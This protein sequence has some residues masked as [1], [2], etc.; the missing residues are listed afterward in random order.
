[1]YLELGQFSQASVWVHRECPAVAVSAAT[2]DVSILHC[3]M[4][5][6]IGTMNTTQ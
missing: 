1:M 3:N 6:S 5:H 2:D 4:G